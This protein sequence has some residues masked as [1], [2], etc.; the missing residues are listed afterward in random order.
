MGRVA[1][2]LGR[3]LQKLLQRFKSAPDLKNN[4]MKNRLIEICE[5]VAEDV[6]RDVKEMD[7]KPFDGRTVATH[8][9][10]QAA[11]IKALADVMKKLIEEQETNAKII[12]V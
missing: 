9:G 11:A 2:R 12:A 10:Y 1:E 6:E 8:F 3:A 7:G 4:N 5:Q